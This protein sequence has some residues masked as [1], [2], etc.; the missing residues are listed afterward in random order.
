VLFSHGLGG[1]RE[2]PAFLGEHWA[3]RGYL[4]VFLQHPGSDESVRKDVSPGQRLRAMEQA[5]SARNFLLRARDVPAVLDQLER[6]N[7]SPGHPLVGRM[8]LGRIGM[9]GHSFG[10]VTT[11]AVSGQSFSWIGSA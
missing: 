7:R 2:G 5:A 4:A 6:W 9:S 1:S 3:G 11:Q 8:D 10:A